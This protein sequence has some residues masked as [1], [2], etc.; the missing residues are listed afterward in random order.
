MKRVLVIGSG[1][2]GLSAAV[3]LAARGYKVKVFEK[4]A[5]TGGK[6][7]S[8]QEDGF[9][10]DLGPTILTMPSVLKRVFEEAGEQLSDY[11]HLTRLEP[12]WR[13]FFS[14]RSVLDLS[15]DLGTMK[16]HLREFV[17]V[18]DDEHN[19]ERFMLE[20]QRLSEL[21]ASYFFWKPVGGPADIID[22]KALLDFNSLRNLAALRPHQTV[23]ECVRDFVKD[24]RT[25]QMLDYLVQY[26]GSSP[27]N[28]PALLCGMAH[29]QAQEGVWYP[30]GGIR[31]I[32]E[33]F[34][35]LAGQLG[36]EFVTGTRVV[37]I[38]YDEENRVTGVVDQNGK[39]HPGVAVVSNMDAVRTH[40]DLLKGRPL[41]NF[42]AR[43]EYEP[44][45]SGVVFYLGLSKR[46][47]QLAHHNFVFSSDSQEEFHHIYQRGDLS[48]DPSIYLAAPSATDPTVAPEGGEALY[49]LAH[50]PYLQPH[51]NWKEMLPGYRRV[52]FKKLAECAGMDDLG[53][54]IVFESSLTPED[55]NH[56][57]Q[58][59][60][61]AL[62][63]LTSHGKVQ[64]AFKP[65]NRSPDLKGL[66]L[67]GGSA[68]PGPGMPMAVM[69]GWIAADALDADGIAKF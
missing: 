56:R 40:R 47:H 8:L 14:D 25:A 35:K 66:Y 4:N 53:E 45:C 19:Y 50:T 10:F 33:A 7:S 51:H 43:R 46:Y 24:E 39:T 55:M 15:E 58:L 1:L 29:M 18:A 13:A 60:N 57:Y 61:G 30:Q 65:C 38:E 17:R 2:G 64:G 20:A 31:A 16:E 68:H 59:L 63:G 23:Q 49:V 54:R 37:S 21:A 28:S 69:S 67:A 11:V 44:T 36:V 3:T 6:T 27:E 12:Q 42:E 41:A 32:P 62:Y 9:R 22:K 26:V 52:I 48:P 34:R 5:W